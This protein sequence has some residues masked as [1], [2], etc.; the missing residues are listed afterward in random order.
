MGCLCSC[1]QTML[2]SSTKAISQTPEMVQCGPQQ[3]R[4]MNPGNQ[5]LGS[6]YRGSLAEQDMQLRKVGMMERFLKVQLKTLGAMLF[7]PFSANTNFGIPC[8]PVTSPPPHTN[9]A[10]NPKEEIEQGAS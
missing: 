4:V 6:M 3:F 2:V 1:P 10:Y 9:V 8:A 5:P 7:M